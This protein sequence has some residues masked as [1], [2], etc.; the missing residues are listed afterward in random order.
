MMQDAQ[1]KS[2]TQVRI[3]DTGFRLDMSALTTFRVLHPD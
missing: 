2:N 3:A 1:T